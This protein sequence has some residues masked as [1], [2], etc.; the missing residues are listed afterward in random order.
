VT[1]LAMGVFLVGVILGRFFKVWILL[2]ISLLAVVTIIADSVS[3]ALGPMH[4]FLELA[5]VVI[6]LQLGYAFGLF[7]GLIAY[8][9][10][11]RR[12]GR[13]TSIVATRH[14]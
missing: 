9:W 11:G 13:M 14:Q 7:S 5:L 8:F 6:C 3:H 4:A 10:R 2:P 12:R 1:I